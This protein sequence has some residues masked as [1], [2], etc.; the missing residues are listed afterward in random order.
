MP[1]DLDVRRSVPAAFNVWGLAKHPRPEFRKKGGDGKMDRICRSF[2]RVREWHKGQTMTEYAMIISAVV[3]VV[4]V[5][6][7]TMGSSLR[8]L[9]QA[10]DNQL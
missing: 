4:L 6:Y 1:I 3:I 9:L 10:L 8:T 7:Q 2:I 5:G